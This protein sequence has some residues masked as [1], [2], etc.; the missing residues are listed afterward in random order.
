MFSVTLTITFSRKKESLDAM[1]D[2]IKKGM[3]ESR[4]RAA[5]IKAQQDAEQNKDDRLNKYAPVLWE[6]LKAV[7]VNDL[8]EIN[9]EAILQGAVDQVLEFR[10]ENESLYI[11][12]ETIPRLGLTL[13]FN[14]MGNTIVAQY[15]LRSEGRTENKG[16]PVC[17]SI[18]VE[19]DG[20]PGILSNSAR[21]DFDEKTLTVDNVSERLL[22]PIV[23]ADLREVERQGLL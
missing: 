8:H 12:R 3:D 1:K 11:S 13:S 5:R 4:D 10:I 19:Y 14:S 16:R 7:I 6:K 9:R 20:E 22:L 18:A 21:R 17:L 2:W 15:N 23:L